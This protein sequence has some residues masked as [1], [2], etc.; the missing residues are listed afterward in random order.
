M[1]TKAEID[2][3]AVGQLTQPSPYGVDVEAGKEYFYCTCGLSKSQPFCDGSHRTSGSGLKP[4]K[5]VAEKTEKAWLCGCRQSANLPYCDGSHRQEKG[6]K[7]YN[8]FLLKAN[9]DLK[10]SVA[11]EQKRVAATSGAAIICGVVLGLALSRLWKQ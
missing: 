9:N 4:K 11:L 10:A 2:I 7:K 3:A 8:E 1:T 6:F 5:F